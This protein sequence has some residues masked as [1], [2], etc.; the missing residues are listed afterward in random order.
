MQ[1]FFL[2]CLASV[3]VFITSTLQ[4]DEAVQQL[5]ASRRYENSVTP[6][7]HAPLAFSQKRLASVAVCFW[8]AGSHFS[9]WLL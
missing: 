1:F 9:T 7:A 6:T 4:G 5:K 2:H 3:R 8:E